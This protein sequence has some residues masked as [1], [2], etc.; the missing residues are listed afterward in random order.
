[1]QDLELRVMHPALEI[2]EALTNVRVTVLQDLRWDDA[3]TGALPQFVRGKELIYAQPAVSFPGGNEW[4]TI[5]LTQPR[6]G[7]GGVAKL[8]PGTARTAVILDADERRS[9][10]QYAERTDHNGAFVPI[11]TDGTDPS[12]HADLFDV[13][14][15]LPLDRPLEH[16]QLYI[17]GGFT[18]YQCL[19]ECRCEWNADERSYIAHGMVKAGIV[20]YAYAWLPD[21]ATVPDLTVIEG[22]HARTE[23]DYLLLVYLKDRLIGAR[24]VNSRP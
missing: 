5:D 6:A 7:T 9:I 24:E 22:S 16:G 10:K 4:R 19:P 18:G 13:T 23:N 8:V 11:T 12:T 1:M 2:D 15:R 3:R 20:D 17:Y 14:W 21:G